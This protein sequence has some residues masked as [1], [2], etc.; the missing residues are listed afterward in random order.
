[1]STELHHHY[2]H[3]CGIRPV[4]YLCIDPECAHR[5]EMEECCPRC[6]YGA[7]KVIAV[8]VDVQRFKEL[9]P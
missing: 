1:M 5:D 2:C 7:D 3:A 6:Y 8:T 9:R 4:R